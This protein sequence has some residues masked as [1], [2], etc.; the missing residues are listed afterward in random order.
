M[1]EIEQKRVVDH[2][3]LEVSVATSQDNSLEQIANSYMEGTVL[4]KRCR[5]WKSEMLSFL[6]PV[7]LLLKEHPCKKTYLRSIFLIKQEEIIELV[8][9]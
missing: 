8:V 3:F 9:K 1:E 5:Q 6:E 2:Q 7:L 4:Q